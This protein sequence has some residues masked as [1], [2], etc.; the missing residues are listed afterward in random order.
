VLA[1]LLIDPEPLVVAP[2]ETVPPDGAVTLPEA[3]GELTPPEPVGELTLPVAGELTV[4]PD[5]EL[6]LTPV[7]LVA[8]VLGAPDTVLPLLTEP[9]APAPDVLGDADGIWAPDTPAASI[10][11]WLQRS[12]S[13]RVSV[14]A[15]MA[16]AGSSIA[17]RAALDPTILENV[18][19]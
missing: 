10:A 11:C 2:E 7:P 5:G 6:V 19:M 18:V 17:A 12:K 15:P 1:E 8:P 13:A 4:L 16:T 3:D 14:S 9:E